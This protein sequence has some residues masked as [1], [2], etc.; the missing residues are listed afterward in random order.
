MEDL[1]E[2]QTCEEVIHDDPE[3]LA[4]LQEIEDLEAEL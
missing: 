3:E 2:G 1:A 4:L